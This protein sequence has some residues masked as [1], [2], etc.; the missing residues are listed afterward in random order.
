MELKE[1]MPGVWQWPTNKL[2]DQE[3][4]E[5]LTK[6]RKELEKIK[7]EAHGKRNHP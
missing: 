3:W 5:R 4:K 6:F 1:V 7:G 2:P